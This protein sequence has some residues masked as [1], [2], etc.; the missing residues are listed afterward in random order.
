MMVGPGDALARYPA[1]AQ[2]A[3]RVAGDGGR[4]Y[5]LARRVR[6]AAWAAAV[7]AG[8]RLTEAIRAGAGPDEVDRL[9][10][11]WRATDDAYGLALEREQRAQARMW[12]AE[13]RCHYIGAALYRSMERAAV[14]LPARA[15]PRNRPRAWR[16]RPVRACRSRRGGTDPPDDP[17]G[18]LA[19]AHKRGAR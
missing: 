17:P 14:C 9:R 6:F 4:A 13:W 16:R 2:R 1:H 15:G 5:R 7:E 11:L 19:R 18:E 3:G 12:A 8:E 10:V